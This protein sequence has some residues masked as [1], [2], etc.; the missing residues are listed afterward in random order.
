MKGNTSETSPEIDLKA[1]DDGQ[2]VED[3]AIR[4]LKTRFQVTIE[5]ALF[6]GKIRLHCKQI[7]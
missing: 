2:D 5:P 4:N 1:P 7:Q 3:S 6:L